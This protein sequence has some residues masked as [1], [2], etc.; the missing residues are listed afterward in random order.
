M[1]NF[2]QVSVTYS[3]TLAITF[4]EQVAGLALR[5]ATQSTERRD[6][7]FE[8]SRTRRGKEQELRAKFRQ[9]FRS[10]TLVW[11]TSVSFEHL[12]LASGMIMIRIRIRI[13]WRN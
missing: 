12:S 7:F 4:R 3:Q 2:I 9:L 5:F 10:L 8:N 6:F 13:E 11:G 1:R